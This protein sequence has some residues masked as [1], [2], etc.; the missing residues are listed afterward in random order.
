M[1]QLV[2]RRAS[3]PD[4]AGIFR[5]LFREY[6]DWLAVDLAFQDFEAELANL[7][8]KYAPPSGA[9]LLAIGAE[10]AV[11]GCIAMRPLE[12]L[13]SDIC[14]MKRLYLRPEARGAGTGRKLAEKLIEVAREAGHRRMVLDTLSHMTDALRLYNR[15]GFRPTDPYYHN[16]IPGVVYLS[17]DL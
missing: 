12:H 5:Q 16:P 8:G 14:E 15:L 10:G 6:V 7:P 4:D 11:I 1:S 17:L 2:I 9:A 13:G 3:F